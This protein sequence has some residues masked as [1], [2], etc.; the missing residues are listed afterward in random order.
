[1]PQTIFYSWQ[2]DRPNKTNRGFI[3][4]ALNKAIRNLSQVISIDEPERGEQISLDKDTK[5]VPGTPPIADVIFEKIKNSSVFVPDLTFITKTENGRFIPNPNVLIEYG[6]ALAKLTHSKIVPVVNEEFGEANSETLP[7]DMKHYRRP[8]TYKLKES[9]SSEE[10]KEIKTELVK[11]LERAI[12]LVLEKSAVQ[13]SKPLP[14]LKKEENTLSNDEQTLLIEASKNSHGLIMR[15]DSKTT[16]FIKINEKEFGSKSREE[17]SRW[18]YALEE[19]ETKNL[20][21]P[22]SRKRELF[23]LTHPGRL[24]IKGIVKST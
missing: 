15:L 8:I 4:D 21:K 5:G 17:F 14:L 22:R 13:N 7:F 10:R 6:W 12:T 16:W 19:L 2:S 11:N 1:M 24:A 23:E 20:I 9:A 3:E 18:D